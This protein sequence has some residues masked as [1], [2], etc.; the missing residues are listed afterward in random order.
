MFQSWW[1]WFFYAELCTSSIS[2]ECGPDC[3]AYIRCFEELALLGPPARTSDI[4]STLLQLSPLPWCP[5][6]LT[7]AAPGQTLPPCHFEEWVPEWR[8]RKELAGSRAGYGWAGLFPECKS[9]AAWGESL[10]RLAGI[11]WV[12][13]INRKVI[14][15]NAMLRWS[16]GV[17]I[18]GLNVV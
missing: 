8:H 15:T 18:Q 5:H 1:S 4:C 11:P 10:S 9:S 6:P 14:G 12:I 7:W 3:W 2:T 13:M 16:E 17:I